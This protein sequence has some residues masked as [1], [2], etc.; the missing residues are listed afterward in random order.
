MN[1]GCAASIFFFLKAS[2]AKENLKTCYR[3][4][5]M[6]TQTSRVFLLQTF[7]HLGKRRFWCVVESLRSCL[8][9]NVNN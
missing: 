3:E 7:I 6:V 9:I 1:C 5:R 8:P 4:R 2:K